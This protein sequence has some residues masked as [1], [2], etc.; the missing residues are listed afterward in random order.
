MATT[1]FYC[2]WDS[3]QVG[4]IFISRAKAVAEWGKKLCTAKV[5][6]MATKCLEAEVEALRPVPSRGSV[7]I[8]HRR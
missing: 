7:R 8:R 5:K 6:E 3:G 1:P 4:F 2:P